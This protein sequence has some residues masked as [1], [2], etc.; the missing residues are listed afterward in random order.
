[1][2]ILSINATNQQPQTPVCLS[3]SQ[4]EDDGDVTALLLLLVFCLISTPE[5][6]RHVSVRE[7]ENER[8][9]VEKPTDLA[10]RHALIV[11]FKTGFLVFTVTEERGHVIGQSRL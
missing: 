11:F 8:V 5:S 6:A 9:S 4:R 2:S 10:A 1:M 7:R 3:V